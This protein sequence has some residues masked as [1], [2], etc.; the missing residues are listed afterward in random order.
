MRITVHNAQ[1]P[2]TAARYWRLK[3]IVTMTM[4]CHP[5]TPTPTPI[6]S[7]RF[8]DVNSCPAT[9]TTFVPLASNHQGHMSRWPLRL[10]GTMTVLAGVGRSALAAPPCREH[11]QQVGNALTFPEKRSHGTLVEQRSLPRPRG[12]RTT[13]PRAGPPCSPICRRRGLRCGRCST[14]C[15]PSSGE[16]SPFHVWPETICYCSRVLK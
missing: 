14:S 5:T 9:I 11:G 2:T 12:L 10:L 3:A 13:T 16:A 8:R 15:R 1:K 4:S 6:A 7:R